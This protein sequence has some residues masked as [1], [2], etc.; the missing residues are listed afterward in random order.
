MSQEDMVIEV[1]NS[2]E[3]AG[4]T[5]RNVDWATDYPGQQLAVDL[6][7]RNQSDLDA[8]VSTVRAALKARGID[9]RPASDIDREILLRTSA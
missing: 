4:I 2:L 3:L 9:S 5:G 7:A 8:A 1:V 6:Y